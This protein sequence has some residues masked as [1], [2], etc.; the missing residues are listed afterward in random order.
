M[1][2]GG[3]VVAG[4][5]LAGGAIG[6]AWDRP[7]VVGSGPAA[8]TPADAGTSMVPASATHGTA[9]EPF[10]GRHQSGILT[11]QQAYGVFLGLNL[12]PGSDLAKVATLL[13]LLSDDAARLTRGAPPLGAL[14]DDIAR[15]PARLTVTFGFGVGLFRAIGKPQAIPADLAALPSFPTDKLQPRWGQTDLVLQICSDEPVTLSY[16]QRRLA[17]DAAAFATVAWVQSGFVNAVGTEK[18]GTTARNLMGMRDGTANESDP[19]QAAQVVWCTDTAYPHLVDGS[20]LVIRRIPIDLEAWDDL[21]VAAKEAGF[22][23]RISDGSPLTGRVERDPVDRNAKDKDGFPV[24]NP[25]AHAAR[26]QARTA[27]E[28]MIRRAYNYDSGLTPEGQTDAGLIFA[29]YQ[30]DV[31]S[32]FVTVQRRLAEKDMLN[33]WTT[34]IGSASYAVPP[35]AAEG[36]YVGQRLLEG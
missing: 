14:E 23:R 36:Q 12:R 35:G 33:L 15:L 27:G 25:A 5:A 32:A 24:V 31:T 2:G 9:Q 22:G 34:H 4:S 13:T 3:A 28:R 11:R 1:L 8:P 30:K 17:R 29:C 16:A 26:A 10:F 20:H 18:S 19:A 6:V 21:E 7:T